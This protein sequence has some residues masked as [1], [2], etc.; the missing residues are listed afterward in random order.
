MVLFE[1]FSIVS[2]RFIVDFF[3]QLAVVFFVT[4]TSQFVAAYFHC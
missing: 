1:A 2:L 3:S 4:T